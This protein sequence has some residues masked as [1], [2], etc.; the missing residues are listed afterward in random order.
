MTSRARVPAVAPAPPKVD[1]LAAKVSDFW[2]NYIE[3]PLYQIGLQN[4]NLRFLA[5]TGATA[6]LLWWFKPEGFFNEKGKPRP[7]VVYDEKDPNA[8]IMDWAMFSLFI[9]FASVLFI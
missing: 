2:W 9:G 5:F 8:V 6:A 4:P 3:L 7:S 1:P